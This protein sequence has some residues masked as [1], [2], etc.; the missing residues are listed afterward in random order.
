M[1]RRVSLTHFHGTRIQL[2]S[3][4]LVVDLLTFRRST[5]TCL[6]VEVELVSYLVTTKAGCTDQRCGPVLGVA[7]TL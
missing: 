3:H 6:S 2:T 7:Y 5:V 4:D 1:V